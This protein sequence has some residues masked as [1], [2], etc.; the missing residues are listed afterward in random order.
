MTTDLQ[1]RRPRSQREN[2]V[3]EH[4]RL[5]DLEPSGDPLGPGPCLGK[6]VAR[7]TAGGVDASGRHGGSLSHERREET[8]PRLPAAGYYE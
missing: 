8:G 3:E 7:L 2:R 5:A 4:P 1:H 6:P